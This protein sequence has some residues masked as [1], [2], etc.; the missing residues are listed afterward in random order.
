MSFEC[1]LGKDRAKKKKERYAQNIAS[2]DNV[3]KKRRFLAQDTKKIGCPAELK[4]TRVAMFPEHKILKDSMWARKHAGQELKSIIRENKPVTWENTYYVLVPR[5]EDHVGHPVR[6]EVTC[7]QEAANPKVEERIKELLREGVKS[8]SE[9]R[10]HVRE[11]V[12]SSL[13]KGEK[14][15]PLTRYRYYTLHQNLRNIMKSAQDAVLHSRNDQENLQILAQTWRERDPGD[16]IFIRPQN[17][18]EDFLLCYQTKWQQR[19]L[20]LYGQEVCLLDAAHKLT[21]SDLP[22]YLLWARTNVCYI[23]VAVFIVRHETEEAVSDALH[24]LKAWNDGWSPGHFIVDFNMAEINAVESVF[25]DCRA[26]LCDYHLEKMWDEWIRNVDNG[27]LDQDETLSS[28][29]RIAA[30]DTLQE[31]EQLIQKFE[32]NK[33]WTKNPLLQTWFQK[34]WLPEKERWINAFREEAVQNILIIIN[35]VERLNETFKYRHLQNCKTS[36]LSEMMTV[37]VND[38]IPQWQKKYTQLNI[39]YSSGCTFSENIPAFLHNR[40]CDMVMHIVDRMAADLG[41]VYVTELSNRTFKV[42]SESDGESYVVTLGSSSTLPSCSC[43][44]WKRNRLPCKHFCAGFREGWT[45]DD[46][47]SQYRNNPLFTLD[48]VCFSSNPSASQSAEE[49]LE[50]Q[51]HEAEIQENDGKDTHVEDQGNEM[52]LHDYATL[53]NELPSR[54]RTNKKINTARRRCIERLKAISDSILSVDNEDFLQ[55]LEITLEDVAMELKD[56]IPHDKR[57]ALNNF[58]KNR[59][60]KSTVVIH[61]TVPPPKRAYGQPKHPCTNTVGESTEIMRKIPVHVINPL[62]TNSLSGDQSDTTHLQET[63]ERPVTEAWCTIGGAVLTLADEHELLSGQRLNDKFINASQSLLRE[64]FPFV[65]GLNDTILLSAGAVQVSAATEAIQIHHM[66]QHWLVSSSF[67][68]QVQL[69]D[70][71]LPKSCVPL[72]LRQQLVTVYRKYCRGQDGIID[73]QIKCT[74][75]QQRAMDSGLFAIANA[76][77]LASGFDPADIQYNQNLMRV[78]LHACLTKG[79][80]KMFPHTRRRSRWTIAERRAILSKYC[81]C[82]LYKE[83]ASMVQCDKCQGWYHSSCVNISASIAEQMLTDGYCC[84][85]CAT[86][87]VSAYAGSVDIV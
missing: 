49:P 63:P 87:L 27:V 79:K 33:E 52:L 47:C 1:H 20:H 65:E 61:N 69:Y 78:H 81:I 36:T 9:M 2:G 68:G 76:V 13:F 28:L 60:R 82:Y 7:V 83:K 56:Y 44:D 58:T 73:V 12:K 26:I 22:L 18:G 39:Q 29:R 74:Q 35:G 54:T 14:P 41:A 57:M 46:L 77:S 45:W 30:A 66:D 43:E 62:A 24:I 15:P 72:T 3:H 6:G 21:K 55:S 48:P 11:F 16:S 10:R 50:H 19:L 23:V 86:E 32:E 37:I 75:R 70:S 71:L 34:T 51:D 4:V 17:E 53:L 31:C 38:F 5:L 40:P 25:T 8:V 59:K 42:T 67:R 85:Q 64:E 80:L 84:T